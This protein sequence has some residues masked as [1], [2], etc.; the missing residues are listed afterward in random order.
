MDGESF[1]QVYKSKVPRQLFAWATILAEVGCGECRT[2]YLINT[3]NQQ[4]CGGPSQ[5]L[6]TASLQ[7]GGSVASGQGA[8][9]LDYVASANPVSLCDPM[10]CGKRRQPTREE[11]G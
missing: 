5:K 4:Q 7:R 11:H 8:D 10:A 1:L 2:G 3:G 6:R 9:M